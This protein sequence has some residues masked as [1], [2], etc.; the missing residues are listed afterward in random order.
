MQFIKKNNQFNLIL[1]KHLLNYLF[2]AVFLFTFSAGFAQQTKKEASKNGTNDQFDPRIDNMRYWM[3]KAEQGIIPYN[4]HI[5]IPPAIYRGNQISAPGVKTV[6]STDI[7]VTNLTDVTESENSVFIDPNNADFL[8]NSNNSTSWTGTTF[9]TLYGASYFQSSNAGIG[10]VGSPTGAGGTNSGDPTTAISLTGRQYINYIDDPGGQGVSYSDNGTSWT[11]AT[12]A[13]NPGSLADKNHMWIDNSLSSTYQGNLYTAWTDF[14][15]T[16][17]Y[18]VVISRSTNNGVTWSSRVPISGSIAYFS[19]GVNLQTGPA[20]QVYAVWATYPTVGLTEDGIGF[21]K[22]LDGGATFGTATKIISNIKGIRGTGVLKNMRV[23]SFPVMAVDIS[24]G[25]N[26]GNIYVVWSNI[27]VPGI[28]TGTNKSIYI[29]RSTNGGTT[30]STPVRINQGPNLDGKEAYSPW[31]SCDAVTGVLSVVFYDD[32]NVSSTQCE[33][34]AA[35]SYNAGNTW[36]DFVVSDVAFTP[37]AIPGL[38]SGYMGDYLG[39]TSRNS[40]VYPCW[41]DNRGGVYMTYV[42]PF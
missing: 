20:G 28:N 9:G 32:R 8:L 37:V 5:P 31:I 26:S 7:P 1:M 3:K 35:Y 34:F 13:P 39:I 24:S 12:I 10:W 14:G 30:W 22:S 25:P 33:T 17:D 38:A 21:N 18:E 42:S 41:T 36:T 27:G 19:H 16:Y 4:P 40:K 11:T 15:G 2:L 6:I 29:I 23:N